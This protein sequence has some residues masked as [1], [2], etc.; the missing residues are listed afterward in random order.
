MADRLDRTKLSVIIGITLVLL[1][2]GFFLLRSGVTVGK[3]WSYGQAPPTGFYWPEGAEPEVVQ[4]GVVADLG[5]VCKDLPGQPQ[6]S[7]YSLL[8]KIAGSQT[9][10]Q[11]LCCTQENSCGAG[12]LLKSSVSLSEV[13]YDCLQ[14]NSYRP[15]SDQDS[16]SMLCDD[17]G[18]ELSWVLCTQNGL[19]SENKQFVCANSK[20]NACDENFKWDSI[21]DKYL[22][23]EDSWIICD[24]AHSVLPSGDPLSPFCNNNNPQ[25]LFG[26]DFNPLNTDAYKKI[27]S[28]SAMQLKG[29]SVQD[30]VDLAQNNIFYN[31]ITP[32]S[33]LFFKYGGNV[34]AITVNSD[35]ELSVDSIN[36]QNI[37]L[38]VLE[39]DEDT[40]TY[41]KPLQMDL[42]LDNDGKADAYLNMIFGSIYNDKLLVV[43]SPRIDFD[44][45]LFSTAVTLLSSGNMQE[46]AFS[47][48]FTFNF[49]ENQDNYLLLVQDKQYV[50]NKGSQGTHYLDELNSK[51]VSYDSLETFGNFAILS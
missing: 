35:H 31:L 8:T 51:K 6:A 14:Q 37:A 20:W 10:L 46:F 5:V 43:V 25:H 12:S 4:A 41:F 7:Q 50:V 49:F 21:N 45:P 22:F 19:L 44:N 27:S 1:I 36:D 33:S 9:Q 2:G 34:Y 42:D 17:Y 48:D 38:E 23:R 24:N 15:R 39:A 26:W 28:V 18:G 11:S 16:T 30:S 3:A 40:R 47:G 13:Y 32:Q 29:N